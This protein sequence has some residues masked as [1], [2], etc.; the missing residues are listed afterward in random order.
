MSD[1]LREAGDGYEVRTWVKHEPS[2]VVVLPGHPQLGGRY[3][4]TDGGD[5]PCAT[6]RAALA[7]H[8]VE[9]APTLDERAR[10]ERDARLR[11]ARDALDMAALWL[12]RTFDLPA[13]D[14]QQAESWERKA[15][16]GRVALAADTPERSAPDT[17]K[18]RERDLMASNHAIGRHRGGRPVQGCPLCEV[19]A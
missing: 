2:G 16:S 15:R 1:E 3:C 5:W 11:D 6:V 9:P 4:Q 12:H 19:P 18:Q 13:R 17:R 14:S 7:A 10:V 8:R